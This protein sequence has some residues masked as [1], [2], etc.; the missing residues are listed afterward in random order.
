MMSFAPSVKDAKGYEL[1]KHGLVAVGAL[2]AGGGLASGPLQLSVCAGA[3][4]LVL[5]AAALTRV[6][7]QLMQEKE[8]FDVGRARLDMYIADLESQLVEMRQAF[9]EAQH[10]WDGERASL[11]NEFETRLQKAT[12]DLHSY[13]RAL[14]ALR[15]CLDL[16]DVPTLSV[17]HTGYVTEMNPKAAEVFGCSKEAVSPRRLSSFACPD[18]TSQLHAAVMNATTAVAN[19]SDSRGYSSEIRFR[20]RC[21]KKSKFWR[22]IV[23]HISAGKGSDNG[24]AA[25]FC[26]AQ[27]ITRIIDERREAE[28]TVKDLTQIINAINAPLIGVDS[29]GM[30]NEWNRKAE[31]LTGYTKDEA[32]GK[33]LVQ[34]FITEEFAD[35]VDLM[36]NQGLKGQDMTNYE[37]S[38]FTKGGQRREILLSA[39]ARR[40]RDNKVVGVV[41]VGKDITELRSES[42]MLSNYVRICGAAVWSLRGHSGT[43]AVDECKTKE[44]EHLISQQ[45]QMDICDPRMVLWRASFVS[46]L[47]TMCQNFWMCRKSE[48]GQEEKSGGTPRSKLGNTSSTS[49]FTIPTSD[50]CYEFCFEAPNGQVKWYKVEGH[51]I[52]ESLTEGK[53]EVNGSMQEVTSMWIDKVMGDR[54]QKWWSRMCHMVFD[55]TL[56]VDTQ[57]YR[58]L[59]AWGEEKVFGCKLQSHHPVLQLIKSEDTVS[60]KEAFNEV[61]F[62]GFERGR[63]LHL[64]RP[65]SQKE[66]P[67]QCFLLSADQENPNECMMGIRMQVSKHGEGECSVLWD[68]AKPSQ[69]LTLEDLARLKSGLKRHRRPS[70]PNVR[71]G[72]RQQRPRSSGPRTSSHSLSSIPE[73]LHGES[74]DG[75]DD[76]Q[77]VSGA[78]VNSDTES[79]HSSSQGS[80]SSRRSEISEVGVCNSSPPRSVS[81]RTSHSQ[82]LG[83]R[84][85]QVELR[86]SAFRA[87]FSPKFDEP[88]PKLTSCHQVRHSI[89]RVGPLNVKLKWGRNSY[90]LNLDDF[91]TV[92]SFREHV[93]ELTNIPGCRQTLILAG[94]RLPLGGEE[95]SQGE[96]TWDELRNSIRPGQTIMLIGSVPSPA[97][98]SRPAASTPLHLA[99]EGPGAEQKAKEAV[100]AAPFADRCDAEEQTEEAV[101][102]KQEEAADS[103]EV[104]EEGQSVEDE[105]HAVA[106]E[107]QELVEELEEELLEVKEEDNEEEEDEESEEGKLSRQGSI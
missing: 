64:L 67:A 16:A 41:G 37:F 107:E 11:T 91:I 29:K 93:Q 20:V 48:Q 94:K 35:S 84:K 51:L 56:L 22:E 39:S 8:A 23:L 36:L 98:L 1:Q 34:N 80:V 15:S 28:M 102:E 14:S 42:K 54:W 49:Y 70:R 73:D 95:T 19:A 43:G 78:S 88:R 77:S 66:M 38:L 68:V 74:E 31:I 50:F 75:E 106:L 12:T 13:Q 25:L 81:D 79:L 55:A 17:D 65:G 89:E 33:N 63:T 97:S 85:D 62:K 76:M 32:L 90:D 92:E 6:Y 5:V 10:S 60:L 46:I 9:T 52:E 87:R 47:K 69:V 96:P 58:V 18:D 71:P 30:V 3:T 4:L 57:E 99:A 72:N 86:G 44:I 45:A 59:N 82:Q 105:E 26:I 101:E 104:Q 40:D 61:T 21:N 2:A 53:F 100:Q 83:P 24:T 27:D 103:K 7:I